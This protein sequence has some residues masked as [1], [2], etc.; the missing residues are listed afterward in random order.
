MMHLAITAAIYC[1]HL[2]RYICIKLQVLAV[3]FKSMTNSA[4]LFTQPRQQARVDCIL[5]CS[6]YGDTAVHWLKEIFDESQ[7]NLKSYQ[8]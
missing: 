5:H 1:S 2:N 3:L 4:S 7:I 8:F 6:E